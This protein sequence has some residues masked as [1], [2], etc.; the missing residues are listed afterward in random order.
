MVCDQIVVKCLILIN[1][2][3]LSNTHH[4]Y[5]LNAYVAN[6]FALICIFLYSRISKKVSQTA[7]LNVIETH[8]NS[9]NTST[10][11]TSAAAREAL[12]KIGKAAIINNT[13]NIVPTTEEQQCLKVQSLV[14]QSSEEAEPSNDSKSETEARQKINCFKF[15]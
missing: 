12:T 7:A 5:A 4:L 14:N 13:T 2:E 9:A 1:I 6:A 10:T 3:T 8:R 11:H 15:I